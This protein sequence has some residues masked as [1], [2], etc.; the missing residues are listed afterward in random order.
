MSDTKTGGPDIAQIR[1]SL[2]GGHFVKIDLTGFST[3]EENP[4]YTKNIARS[5]CATAAR[6]LDTRIRTR[7]E[8][9][10]LMAW[11]EDETVEQGPSNDDEAHTDTL[12]YHT[13]LGVL[14]EGWN[15][16]FASLESISQRICSVVEKLQ[17]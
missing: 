17:P 10:W 1:E 9:E 13:V 3:W 7:T 12:L 8:G 11:V 14:Y 6:A 2:R 15:D 5:R 4:S 16:D